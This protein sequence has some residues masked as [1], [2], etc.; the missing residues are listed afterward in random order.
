MFILRII[1]IHAANIILKPRCANKKVNTQRNIISGARRSV[2][3]VTPTSTASARTSTLY[4]TYTFKQRSEFES[5]SEGPAFSGEA[6]RNF[7][8]FPWRRKSCLSDS[9]FFFFRERVKILASERQPAVFL[10]CYL[11]SFCWQKEKSKGDFFQNHPYSHQNN[12]FLI[13]NSFKK[14]YSHLI[15]AT[16]G[17]T[18]PTIAS[19]KAPPPVVM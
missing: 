3:C 16:P 6:W 13:K 1:L 19:N 7:C 14:N 15:A 12:K 8:S 2:Y 11:F 4:V 10:F 17:R 18:L 9:E 5:F